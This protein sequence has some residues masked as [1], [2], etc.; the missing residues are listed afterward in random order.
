MP[1]RWTP[2]TTDAIEKEKR[3]NEWQRSFSLPA[4]QAEAVQ[5]RMIA[6]PTD[7]EASTRMERIN[8][9]VVGGSK[10]RFGRTRGSQ[11]SHIDAALRRYAAAPSQQEQVSAELQGTAPAQR[12]PSRSGS[13]GGSS[14]FRDLGVSV[15][16]INGK[17]VVAPQAGRYSE[18]RNMMAN[19]GLEESPTPKNFEAAVRQYQMMEK[20][21]PNIEVKNQ[22]AARENEL[23]RQT[24]LRK[25]EIEAGGRVDAANARGTMGF[26]GQLARG[27]FSRNGANGN[28]EKAYNTYNNSFRK[29][30]NASQSPEE[31]KASLDKAGIPY[32]MKEVGGEVQILPYGPNYFKA[33]G[34]QGESPDVMSMLQ[35]ARDFVFPGSGASQNGG[36]MQATPAPQAVQPMPQRPAMPGFDGNAAMQAGQSIGGG[37]SQAQLQQAAAT[38]AEKLPGLIQRRSLQTGLP[39]Y[40][41]AVNLVQDLRMK[42][43][44]ELAQIAEEYIRT[45]FNDRAARTQG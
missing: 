38:A 24:D 16:N 10:D 12:R 14:L 7:Y 34:E 11:Q 37:L 18:Y 25:A 39:P 22:Y 43:Q 28:V 5:S 17:S 9:D 20:L 19:L 41:A 30:A 21:D 6:N 13:E 44:H 35:Q 15:G 2:Y 29:L 45:Q 42:G 27:L 31:F 1:R 32:Q 4:A 36:A 8:A 26:L 33:L 3:Y 40:E 23:R